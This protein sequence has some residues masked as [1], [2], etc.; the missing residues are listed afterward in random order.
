MVHIV[1]EA[2]SECGACGAI[3][4]YWK[5]A[6]T[7]FTWEHSSTFNVLL[8]VVGTHALLLLWREI[9][10]VVLRRLKWR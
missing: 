3:Q 1:L 7:S 6:I 2:W 9:H 4:V 5:R 10:F 8:V